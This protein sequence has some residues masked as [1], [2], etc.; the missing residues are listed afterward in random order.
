[1]RIRDGTHD[2]WT[3]NPNHDVAVIAIT[4]PPEFARA[5]IPETWLASDDT[6]DK[7][8][9]GPGD[10]MLALGFPEGLSANEAGFPILRAGRVASFPLSPSSAFQT[11]LM[12]FSVF[13]GNSGGPVYM[14]E[15]SRRRPGAAGTEDAVFVAGMLTRQVE[16]NGQNLSIGIVVHAKFIRE[17]LTL[18]DDPAAQTV[19]AS[20]AAQPAPVIP[21]LISAEAAAVA[22]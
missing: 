15:A 9:L 11:F 1:M 20:A 2:L 3:R 18:L 10:E 6:F 13:P 4:A 12:D 7:Y 21:G 19:S 14:S 5:A 8:A 17:T 16:M 22:R